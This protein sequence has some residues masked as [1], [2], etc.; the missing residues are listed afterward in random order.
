MCILNDYLMVSF[1]IY[2][3]LLR[4]EFNGKHKICL[5]YDFCIMN[6]SDVQ[7]G[8]TFFAYKSDK[9]TVSSFRACKIHSKSAVASFRAYKTRHKPAVSSFRALKTY[10]KSSCI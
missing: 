10:H 7:V 9:S 6:I 4:K 8:C 3:P 1:K 5:Q 2:W